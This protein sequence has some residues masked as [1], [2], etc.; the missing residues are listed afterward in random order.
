MVSV[1]V[2]STLV[3]LYR[4]ISSRNDIPDEILGI[5]KCCPKT[6]AQK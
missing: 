5:R 2:I 1:R 6:G 4:F 3:E